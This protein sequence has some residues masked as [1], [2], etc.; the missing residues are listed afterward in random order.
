MPGKHGIE[1]IQHLRTSVKFNR[2]KF[3]LISGY[4]QQEDV[5]GV[6]E[7]GVK[8]IIVKP[9]TRQQIVSQVADLLKINPPGTTTIEK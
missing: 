9:F 5:L 6:I 3:I 8:N 4:L 2:M 1:F 7:M